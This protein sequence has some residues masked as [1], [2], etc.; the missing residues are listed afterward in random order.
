LADFYIL[1]KPDIVAFEAPL[2]SMKDTKAET[3]RLLVGLAAIVEQFYHE[4]GVEVVEKQ[5]SSARKHFCGNGHA[6][7]RGVMARCSELGWL[8]ADNNQADAHALWSLVA[9]EIDPRHAHRTSPI[10]AGARV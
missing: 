4:R 3:I 7:K 8:Y 6:G 9:A 5:S 2:V 10:F 1:T